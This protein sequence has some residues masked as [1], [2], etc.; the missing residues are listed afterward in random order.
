MIFT[1]NGKRYIISPAAD[2]S[3]VVAEVNDHKFKCGVGEDEENA[4][5]LFDQHLNNNVCGV[6]NKFN[7][8]YTKYGCP[9]F[10][11][12]RNL[13]NIFPDPLTR[14]DIWM[15][16]TNKAKEEW[17]VEGIT[18]MA[19]LNV[20]TFNTAAVE[21]GCSVKLE[22]VEI[23]ERDWQVE[24][25]SS[26]DLH[27]LRDSDYNSHIKAKREELG[28]D[29]VALLGE[30]YA[31][32][33]A[34]RDTAFSV[35]IAD[36]PLS[37]A[38]EIG[39]NFGCRHDRN[40]QQT[41]NSLQHDFAHGY[42][43]SVDGW[44]FGTIMAYADR[45]V[46]VFSNPN[47]YYHGVAMGDDQDLDDQ[48][49]SDPADSLLNEKNYEQINNSKTTVAAFQSEAVK[50][51]LRDLSIDLDY[52]I[53]TFDF[54]IPS[55]ITGMYYIDY[56]NNLTNWSLLGAYQGQSNIDTT[57]TINDSFSTADQRFYRCR[58]GNGNSTGNVIGFVI[59]Y[60]L[61]GQTM[62]ANPLGTDDNRVFNVLPELSDGTVLYKWNAG[63]Q[64]Y[65]INSFDFDEWDDPNMSFSPGE[66]AIIASPKVQTIVFMGEPWQSFSTSITDGWKIVSSAIPQSG[67]LTTALEFP[68]EDLD[69][70]DSI[71]KMTSSAGVYTQHTVDNQNSWMTAE[72]Q[73]GVGEAFWVHTDSLE[74]FPY[75]NRAVSFD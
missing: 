9:D 24:G 2:G 45:R 21:S 26:T 16:Y 29:L 46:P 36:K 10:E 72:P 47:F 53:F 73:V 23:S 56:S 63:K 35:T 71:Y 61:V 27:S 6:F 48:G 52:A 38:H 20:G 22:I 25:S 49:E 66:G 14:V 44:T 70:G 8:P 59:K 60:L 55:E 62:I 13:C 30:G 33:R 65:E 57:Y 5:I 34:F 68:V 32:S 7:T 58:Y 15:L 11:V 12:K 75:W 39:H 37:F 31:D 19:I 67:Y 17:G 50:I 69:V 28:A 3:H 51:N 1:P 42:V 40:E 74:S 54:F 41:K 4:A 43:T 64:Q 18:S